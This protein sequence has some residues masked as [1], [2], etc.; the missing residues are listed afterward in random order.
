MLPLLSLPIPLT[1]PSELS[2]LSIPDAFTFFFSH[3]ID[4]VPFVLD[5]T[6]VP[7]HEPSF[8]GNEN[9]NLPTKSFSINLISPKIKSS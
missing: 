4:Q 1:E 3:K 5:K 2:H 8:F 9:S 6:Y 7:I